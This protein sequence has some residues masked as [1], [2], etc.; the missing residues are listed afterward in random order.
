MAHGGTEGPSHR[1][2]TSPFSARGEDR[3][4]LRGTGRAAYGGRVD[5]WGR[6]GVW[7]VVLNRG[8]FGQPA[9]LPLASH[10][11][12]KLQQMPHEGNQIVR[13]HQGRTPCGCTIPPTPPQELLALSLCLCPRSYQNAFLLLVGGFC[14]WLGG[15]MTMFRYISSSPEPILG[16][17]KIPHWIITWHDEWVEW[18]DR[19]MTQPE[20]WGD[21]NR[22]M[23]SHRKLW[24]AMTP[25]VGHH[26]T[27]CQLSP[28]L[29]CKNP[30]SQADRR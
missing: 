3:W 10:S 9:V 27:E 5:G 21:F 1:W 23:T 20:M 24:P 30:P 18:G 11:G 8:L 26:A 2:Q 22:I 6:G 19:V 7:W 15:N 17:Y 12:L 16:S 4:T 14:P 25:V 29:C 13:S 28:P